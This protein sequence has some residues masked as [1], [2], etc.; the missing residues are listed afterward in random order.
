MLL[1]TWLKQNWGVALVVAG[2]LIIGAALLIFLQPRQPDLPAYQYS[3]NSTPSYEPGGINCRPKVLSTIK[4]RPRALRERNRCA[5]LTEDYRLKRD[6][7]V[8]QARTADAAAAQTALAYDAARMTL[9]ATVGSFLTLIAASLAAYFARDASYAAR[10]SLDAFT[11]VERA[12]IV[13]TLEDIREHQSSIYIIDKGTTVPDGDADLL[14]DV[15]AHNLGRSAA[16]ITSAVSRWGDSPVLQ[17]PG[18]VFSGPPQTYIVKAAGS[19]RITLTGIKTME[20]LKKARFLW[21]LLSYKSPLRERERVL[22]VCLEVTGPNSNVPY[23]ERSR[24]ERDRIM[25]G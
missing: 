2:S 6:D 23:R 22:Q 4:D 5:E 21:V 9:W 13:I 1:V 25:Q 16:L 10:G 12:E 7:L 14:F 18:D 3:E 19:V 24:E 8:Q 11:E 17:E 20:S 15:V